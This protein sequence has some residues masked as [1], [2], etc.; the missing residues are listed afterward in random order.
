MN[1]FDE[2]WLEWL[3]GCYRRTAHAMPDEQRVQLE[4]AFYAG[5]AFAGRVAQEYGHATVIEAINNHLDRQRPAVGKPIR[6]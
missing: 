2:A 5:A 6:K 1:A 4:A 3:S